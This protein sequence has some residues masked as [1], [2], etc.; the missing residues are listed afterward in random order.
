M[1]IIKRTYFNGTI[2]YFVPEFGEFRN[3]SEM[4]QIVSKM[5]GANLIIDGFDDL[6]VLAVDHRM[7]CVGSTRIAHGCI[8]EKSFLAVVALARSAKKFK[9][10]EEE[11]NIN[12]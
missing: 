11:L 12:V 10:K 6:N 7:N 3:L 1:K 4:I 5:I 8:D 9:P 2:A